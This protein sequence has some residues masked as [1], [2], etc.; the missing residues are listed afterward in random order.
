LGP[1]LLQLGYQW[2][3]FGNPWIP[4]QFHMP[5]Q[6][7]LGYPSERGFGWPLPAALWGLIFDPLYGLLV[8]A[9]MFALAVYHPLLIWRKR[10]LIP[11]R[12]ALFCWMFA[13]AL[14]VFSS[15]I[16]Y[17]VRH[18]WQDGVRYLVPAVPFLFLLVGDVLARMP[19]GLAWLVAIAAVGETWA[20]AMVRES[21][22]ES[23]ARVLTKGFQYPWLTTLSNAATQYFPPLG[24][25]AS[26]WSRW[27]PPAV[28][29][30]MFAMLW[31]I[32]RMPRTRPSE[33]MAASA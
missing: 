16:H 25:P 33:G 19:R 21:P 10:N 23:L 6:Y 26:V 20:L 17:T 7:F 8:F 27:L 5:K 13:V 15:C 3:C 4:P 31:L 12:V 30:A 14:W 29:L 18:Q 1:G 24:D 28:A 22:L 2:Y 9:P 11:G 32:W